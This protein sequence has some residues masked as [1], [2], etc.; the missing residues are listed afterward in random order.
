MRSWLLPL[1]VVAWLAPHGA[2]ATT[3][4]DFLVRNTRDLVDLCTTPES[5]PLYTAAI[6]FCHGY[7]VAAFHYHE[8]LNAKA[9]HKNLCLPNPRP[10]RTE[11][12]RHFIEW[13]K[14]N[15]QYDDEAPVETLVK[16]LVEKWPCPK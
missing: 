16:F 4:D 13:T 15:P 7:L 2:R 14:A 11:G 3:D 12:V 5:D 6:N 8:E 1:I 9:K 10:T